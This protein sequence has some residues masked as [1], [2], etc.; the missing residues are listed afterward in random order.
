MREI[1]LFLRDSMRRFFAVFFPTLILIVGPTFSPALATPDFFGVK[2]KGDDYARNLM[3]QEKDLIP[4]FSN[5]RPGMD[6]RIYA[7]GYTS[8][9]VG[10]GR[11]LS[12][13]VYNHSE[14]EILTESLMRECVILT[15]DGRRYDHSRPEMEWRNDRLRAGADATFN[16]SFSGMDIRKEDVRMITL[17]FGLGETKLYLFPFPP[18][19]SNELF[20]QFVSKLPRSEKRLPP[21]KMKSVLG[22]AGKKA[23]D[24]RRLFKPAHPKDDQ[25][26]P[27]QYPLINSPQIIGG[28][29]YNIS[30]VRQTAQEEGEKNIRHYVYQDRPWSMDHPDWLWQHQEIYRVPEPMVPP[31]A[32]AQVVIANP[33]LKYVVVNAGLVDGVSR[34]SI[35]EIFREGRRIGKAMVR[36]VRDKTAA[37]VTLPEWERNEVIEPGDQ[38]GLSS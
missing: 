7:Y 11:G 8:S 31:R 36:Q 20:S 1:R 10:R 12:I 17:S 14:K 3:V 35:L 2:I 25:E 30:P 32:D 38:V 13:V 15:K 4:D 28:T 37:A 34:G 5:D 19:A 18:N 24:K 29:E 9:F 6:R 21:D 23:G 22:G 27:P 33:A 16:L 26:L